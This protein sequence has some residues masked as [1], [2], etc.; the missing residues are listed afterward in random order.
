MQDEK[1]LYYELANINSKK[2]VQIIFFRSWTIEILILDN[3]FESRF[4]FEAFILWFFKFLQVALNLFRQEK[5]DQQ[6]SHFKMFLK[7]YLTMF[8]PNLLLSIC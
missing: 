2:I 3:L 5:K 1:I 8:F 7:E 4:C 6:F